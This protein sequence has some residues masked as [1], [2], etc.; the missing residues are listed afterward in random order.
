MPSDPIVKINELREDILALQRALD[1][2]RLERNWAVTRAQALGRRDAASGEPRSVL[3]ILT[4]PGVEPSD[5]GSSWSPRSHTTLLGE[6][7]LVIAASVD[8]SYVKVLKSRTG[9][10][11]EVKIR[12]ER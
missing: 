7:D 12:W 1:T 11:P 3:V 5:N 8:D 6:A 10:E 2:M 9:G 4:P